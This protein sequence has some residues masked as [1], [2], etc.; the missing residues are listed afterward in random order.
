MKIATFF[1][2]VRAIKKEIRTL[3]KMLEQQNR[4]SP[5]YI[6]KLIDEVH[7]PEPVHYSITFPESVDLIL[8]MPDH[9][10][11]TY[12]TLLE[13]LNGVGTAADVALITRRARAVES[14]LLNQLVRQGKLVK[15]RKGR[16]VM[17]SKEVTC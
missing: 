13:K 17:F 1:N 2:E 8:S 3:T 4:D 5:T 16:K 14:S 15:R 6:I 11:L 10:R 12:R 7:Q 9:I